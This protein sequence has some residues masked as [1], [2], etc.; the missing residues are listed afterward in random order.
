MA[1]AA[2][3][4]CTL[5]PR[6]ALQA[7]LLMACAGPDT[8][9]LAVRVQ[10]NT[11]RAGCRE[12]LQLAGCGETRAVGVSGA[13]IQIAIG[14]PAKLH[15]YITQTIQEIDRPQKT[16]WT[17]VLQFE[18]GTKGSSRGFQPSQCLAAPDMKSPYRRG[19]AE[20]EVAARQ[21]GISCAVE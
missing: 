5:T 21:P 14:K 6:V 10:D 12:N 1:G 8:H 3:V 19:G 17:R 15:R 13:K 18:H 16:G 4:G 11:V 2:V 7:S 9:C 20:S